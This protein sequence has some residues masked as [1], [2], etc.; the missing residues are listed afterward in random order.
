MEYNDGSR[1]RDSFDPYDGDRGSEGYQG[2]A[3]DR[4]ESGYG[5]SDYGQSPY[6][7][8]PYAQSPYN[9]GSYSG[10]DDYGSD[11]D[12]SGRIPRPRGESDYD[13]GDY[14]RGD[15]YGRDDRDDLARGAGY[16]REE[17]G[18]YARGDTYGR[19]DRDDPARGAGYGREERGDYARSD[20]YGRDDRDDYARSDSDYAREAGYGRGERGEYA[21]GDG[22]GRGGYDDYPRGSEMD[23]LQSTGRRKAPRS[24]DL[25]DAPD[26]SP[27]ETDDYG[28]EEPRA[29]KKKKKRSKFSRFMRGLGA[30][31]AQ[32]PTQTLVLFGGI[33]AVVLVGV[34]LLV[35]L[36][37]KTPKET[38]VADNGQLSIADI[39]PTP[40]LAPTIAPPEMTVAPSETPVVDPFNGSF[41]KTIG[42][43][44]DVIPAVQERLVELNY[45]DMP[46]GGYTK[47]Y[48]TATKN[49][50]RMFQIKNYEDSDDWDGCLGLGTY[51]LL[52][53]DQA[54]PFYLARGDGDSRTKDI[55]TLVNAVKK[56]QA[57]LVEL[58][59][60]GAGSDTGVFG[61]GTA[62]A[63]KTFQQYHGLLADGWAGQSTLNML[64]SDAAMTAAVGKT[65]PY[66]PT[67][68]AGA[69]A[70]ADTGAAAA[71]P[72]PNAAATP[73]ASISE[74]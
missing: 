48:G 35:I 23:D 50:I 34:I 7:R 60:L 19:E 26:E 49:G 21:R 30:Y 41:I 20:G 5:R 58:G 63:V 3:P 10:Y 46:E 11:T 65:S 39:T 43:E 12:R 53:S 22:Y 44:N 32:L 14:A 33:V 1:D 66:T 17:R 57:R 62:T 61:S 54:K 28:S 72:D 59:Y 13:R 69:A 31:I 47:R 68:D 2:G 25:A 15:G 36:L 8:S 9:G 74:N 6:S 27:F 73:D 52:M 55:T 4:G 71:T 64:Y 18:D 67:P 42:E 29:P 45:M 38:D 40:S 70:P 56:L 16:G 37:P 24:Y 51:T